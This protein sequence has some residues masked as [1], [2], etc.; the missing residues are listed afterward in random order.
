MPRAFRIAIAVLAFAGAFA[1]PA[2]ALVLD[3]SALTWTP[4]SLS[5]SYDID[6][7]SPGNDVTITFTHTQ[8]DS[9]G[10]PFIGDFVNGIQ[11]P[12][13]NSNLEGGRGPNVPSL[14]VAVDLAWENRYV[15]VTV[16]FSN[17]YLQGVEG[18]SFSLSTSTA[19][20]ATWISIRSARYL[21]WQR[22][23]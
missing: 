11:T 7:A 22:T 6:P 9:T 21:P 20:T 5:N 19:S 23:A 13:V 8:V 2:D 4:G 1:R 12:A 16:T 14:N 18:V 3:W 15:T 17:S 10:S